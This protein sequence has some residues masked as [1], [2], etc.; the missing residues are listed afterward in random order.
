[1]GYY[2]GICLPK[3]KFVCKFAGVEVN[4]MR[5]SVTILLA[6]MM[7]VLGGCAVLADRGQK[8]EDDKVE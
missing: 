6:G 1:L 2:D 7:L 5:H 4:K 3:K 8:S